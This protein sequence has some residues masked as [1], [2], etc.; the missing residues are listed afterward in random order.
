MLVSTKQ[1]HSIYSPHQYFLPSSQCFHH[2]QHILTLIQILL[3]NRLHHL[4]TVCTHDTVSAYF[5]LE[6]QTLLH[7]HQ[8]HNGEII[9]LPSMV[10]HQLFQV[11]QQQYHRF[12]LVA[13]SMTVY[14][15]EAATWADKVPTGSF[16]L[17]RARVFDGTI[18]FSDLGEVGLCR[19]HGFEAI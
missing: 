11:V 9:V 16:Q 12:H 17:H 13:A 6:A 18:G 8:F 7:F 1:F 10:I 19:R 15:Y 2:F 14:H 4:K 5:A 3:H